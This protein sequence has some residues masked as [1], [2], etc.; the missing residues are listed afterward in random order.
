MARRTRPAARRAAKAGPRAYSVIELLIATVLVL[1]MA[2]LAAVA[3]VSWR[4]GAGLESGGEIIR[5]AVRQCAEDAKRTGQP[6]LLVARANRDGSTTLAATPVG[7]D[8]AA[9]A[10]FLRPAEGEAAPADESRQAEPQ[11]VEYGEIVGWY[12]IEPGTADGSPAEPAP[13]DDNE[14]TGGSGRLGS[15]RASAPRFVPL[16]VFLPDG[17]MGVSRGPTAVLAERGPGGRRLSIRID[18]WSHEV[19]LVPLTDQDPQATP[20]NEQ[21]PEPQ[22][23]PI[24]PE[25]ESNP[26]PAPS[27]PKPPAANEPMPPRD[28]GKDPR[29]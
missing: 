19:T 3:F 29:R 28:D 1:A 23:T 17:Q 27:V 10:A 18:A 12:T 2:S 25:S 24:E 5:L 22:T 6:M 13:N 4:R 16:G 9:I 15:Q 26:D 11:E 20:K 8:P 21:D 7:D 14:P